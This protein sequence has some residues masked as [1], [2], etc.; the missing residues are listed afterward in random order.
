MRITP[1]YTSRNKQD[2]NFGVASM[3]SLFGT[4]H[5]IDGTG[6]EV[7]NDDNI[8]HLPDPSCSL[9]VKALIEQLLVW[10]PGKLGKDLRMDGPMA[11]WFAETRARTIATGDG[12]PPTQ[13]LENRYLSR[14][15]LQRR[16]V[17]P[18]G[19]SA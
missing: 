2:P 1:H 3:S 12:R 11:L 16:Y 18:Q 6:R 10:A 15:A 14:G 5:R 9:G 4:T 13:F 8:I 7:H 17:L 19:Y